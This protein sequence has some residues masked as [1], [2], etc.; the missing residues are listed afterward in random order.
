MLI[1]LGFNLA[2]GLPLTVFPCAL[3]GLGKYPTKTA[4]RTTI[5][6]ARVPLFM[7]VLHRGGG[8]IGIAWSVTGCS[9]AESALL[10][11]ATW[12][13]LPGLRFSLALV[14]RATFRT[15]RGFS[16]DAFLAMIAGRISFQTD[17]IVIGLCLAAAPI[18]YFVI[19]AR[20]VEYAKNGLRA[21]TTVLAPAVSTME[22]R[23]DN[24]GIRAILLD[25]TRHVLWVIVPIQV[26]MIMLGKPFLALW[27]GE[28]YAE[29]SYPTLV[30][31][32]VPLS[33][34]MAQSVAARMLYGLGRLRWFARAMLLE[35]GCN[36]LLSLAMVRPFGIEGVALGTCIPNFIMNVVILAAV[37]RLLRLSWKVYLRRAFAGP[38]FAGMALALGW[39]FAD[40]GELAVTRR[41]WFMTGAL[42]TFGYVAIAVTAEWHGWVRMGWLK[43][44]A[45]L[46][47]TASA[48]PSR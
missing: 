1:L 43:R 21:L 29:L 42:G 44:Q 39:W 17:A 33:L 18:T 30:I 13:L 31:L 46:A 28:R 10:M 32:S 8:L 4:I 9:L 15:I 11:A 41:D 19:A 48:T 27:M 16:L 37:C 38:C 24:E 25:G 35:A 34:A 36:L 2:I 3:D 14:D 12:R 7:L 26:G 5:L 6:L 20:L 40:A 23:G 22:A 45:E 47:A